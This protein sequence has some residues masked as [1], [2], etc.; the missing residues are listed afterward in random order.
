[1]PLL[2]GVSKKI[3]NIL[4]TDKKSPAVSSVDQPTPSL[5][6]SLGDTRMKEADYSAAVVLYNEA[7]KQSPTDVNLLLSRS[8]A[9]MMS[10]PSR[11]DLASQ[12]ADA[13][14]KHDPTNWR[15]WMR[16]GDIH[17]KGGDL[18]RAE[19]ALVNAAQFSQG[20]DM[21]HAQQ[22]LAD[23]RSRRVQSSSTSSAAE[24]SG[25]SVE[26]LLGPSRQTESLSSPQ[27]SVPAHSPPVVPVSSTPDLAQT[28][29]VSVSSGRQNSD[30]QSRR[31]QNSSRSSSAESSGNSVEPLSGPSR[32]ITSPFLAPTPAPAHSPP[33]VP[34]SSTPNSA[35]T[36]SVSVESRRV[37]SSLASLAAESSGNSVEPLSGLSQQ[38]TPLSSTAAPTRSPSVVPVSSI[39][40]STQ[41]PSVSMQSDCQNSAAQQTTPLSPLPTAA[42]THSP[43]IATVSSTA[44]STQTSSISVPSDREHSCALRPFPILKLF[45]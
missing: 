17:L 8:L 16:K 14:I 40:N 24:S 3:R 38:T 4:G 39:A 20:M 2:V 30:V 45:I 27:T 11:L 37:K 32:Q 42:P 43:P 33:V 22:C 15:G 41:I 23:V 35:Q 7:L 31:V 44:N 29:S 19:E 34:V 28:P 5:L 9:Y 36:T 10:T 26:P 1:M 21:L 12:D 13:A 25:N 18:G 6:R